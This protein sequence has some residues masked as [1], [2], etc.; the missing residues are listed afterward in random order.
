VNKL[1]KVNADGT[2]GD[3]IKMSNLKPTKLELQFNNRNGST[4]PGTP[5]ITVYNENDEPFLVYSFEGTHRDNPIYICN[6]IK[7]YGYPNHGDY[8]LSFDSLDKPIKYS[9]NFDM[10]N[11]TTVA[12][13]S[14]YAKIYSDA[15][16]ATPTYIT[17]A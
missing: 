9:K 7:L 14:Y 2:K 17:L 6:M 12:A 10:S 11:S 13:N 8:A 4:N 1:Y 5:L 16:W 3:E 15:F